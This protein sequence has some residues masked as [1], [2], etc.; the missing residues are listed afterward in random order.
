LQKESDRLETLREVVTADAW[1][2]VCMRALKQAVDGDAR[3][4]EWLAKYLLPEVGN[5]DNADEIPRDTEAGLLA[6]RSDP[7]YLQFLRMRALD[8]DN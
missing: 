4:R 3:A 2:A 1:R 8:E 5:G 6:L 7:D